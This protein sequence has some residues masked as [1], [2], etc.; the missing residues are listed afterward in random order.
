M[1]AAIVVGC[2]VLS[3]L[4]APG[5]HAGIIGSDKW[6]YNDSYCTV[7]KMVDWGG[8]SQSGYLDWGEDGGKKLM[9]MDLKD[10]IA[11]Q[12]FI[13]ALKRCEAFQQCVA[14]RDGY[15]KPKGKKPKH[16]YENGRHK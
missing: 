15:T 12:K 7:E 9:A 3:V 6:S 10:V 16:C 14:E 13:P 2:V 4:S 5:A 8:G 11:L 1:K